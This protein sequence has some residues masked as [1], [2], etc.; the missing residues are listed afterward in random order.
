MRKWKTLSL[1]WLLLAA[2]LTGARQIEAQE[3]RVAAAAD[4]KYALDEVIAQFE[5]RHPGTSVSATY[6]SSG[7]LFAQ[8]DND[9]PFDL[10][11][12][13]DARLPRRLV[14]RKKAAPN[15]FFLYATG[16]LVIW[17]PNASRID[18]KT[19]KMRALTAPSVRKI[20]IAN[21]QHAPYGQAAV[22]AMNK[23]GFYGQARAKLVL[24]ENVAQAAQF[25]EVGA[26][27]I[28]IIALSLAKSPKMQKAGRYWEIPLSLFPRLEQGGIIA[29]SSRN[30]TIARQFLAHLTGKM[31]RAVLQSYGFILP[32]SGAGR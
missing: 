12:S 21:P 15:S 2:S 7:N 30:P 29:A 18:V 8:L 17:V 25:I 11:L 16:R 24:G 10:F 14:Q 6:G 26:A 13:A 28:G 27:D 23:A 19:L 31:G 5:N 3:I 22:A 4:L 20:S 1:L 9:A 32:A